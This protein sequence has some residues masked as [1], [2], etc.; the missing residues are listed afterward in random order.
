MTD[1]KNTV[2]DL[3]F[4]KDPQ[5]IAE[6]EKM[7]GPLEEILKPEIRRKELGPVDICA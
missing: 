4:T 2:I 5:W 1:E 7:W 6:R 3:S